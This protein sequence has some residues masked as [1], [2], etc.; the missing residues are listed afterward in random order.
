MV[1]QDGT[2]IEMNLQCTSVSSAQNIAIGGESIKH[3]I[4][5]LASTVQT[6]YEN[7]AWFSSSVIRGVTGLQ[8][9]Q[10]WIGATPNAGPGCPSGCGNINNSLFVYL[11]CVTMNAV[12]CVILG[13]SDHN[14][15]GKVSGFAQ[16]AG[17][18][19]LLRIK[20][21]GLTDDNNAGG[22]F[23]Y[24]EGF[25]GTAHSREII[26]G[27]D[28]GGCPD[29]P[30]SKLPHDV[31][32][33][34]LATAVPG[35]AWPVRGNGTGVA[36]KADVGSSYGHYQM[37][38]NNEGCNFFALTAPD[39]T[40][41]GGNNRG[42]CAIDMQPNRT[43]ATQV[44]S[45]SRSTISGGEANTA[46]GSFASVTGGFA[47]RANDLYARAGGNTTDAEGIGWDCFSGGTF[48]G[49]GPGGAQRCIV[50][51]R[52]SVVNGTVQL[53]SDGNAPT[54]DNCINNQLLSGNNSWGGYLNI[55]GHNHSNSLNEIFWN[56]WQF[57]MADDSVA[58]HT[59]VVA[60]S[61]PTPLTNGTTTGADVALSA[62]TTNGC[63]KVQF[64]S[65][66]TADTWDALATVYITMAR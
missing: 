64:T 52:G 3:D 30:V 22:R 12:P 21:W 26:E 54:V 51:M 57:L 55:V 19:D 45:G 50:V 35:F 47:N 17:T 32:I 9:P 38:G 29:V 63:L 62:D 4:S 33:E 10:I 18:F 24:F 13:D 2:R 1:I 48:S 31:Y 56:N 20:C 44:A 36:V 46:A 39:T 16:D 61:K 7:W 34:Q 27:S 42:A 14:F 66:A 49:G 6:S 65:P 58:S 11:D 28:T 43:D 25:L 53:T 60:G 59:V 15:F 8:V 23:A 40:V 5:G 37:F 41:E